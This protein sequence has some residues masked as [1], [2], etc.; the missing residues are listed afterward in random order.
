[1]SPLSTLLFLSNVVF[2]NLIYI[3]ARDDQWIRIAAFSDPGTPSTNP[4]ISCLSR[5]TYI[6]V[7]VWLLLIVAGLLLP[8]ATGTASGDVTDL[9]DL[10]RSLP[11]LPAIVM[12]G[13]VAAMLSTADAQL[14]V[15][16]QL[17]LVR[18]N[19][20]ELTASASVS[21]RGLILGLVVGTVFA[22]LTSWVTSMGI[23]DEHL[24]FVCFGLPVTIFPALVRIALRRHV[25]ISDVVAPLMLYLALSAYGLVQQPEEL[26]PYLLG[27]APMAGMLGCMIALCRAGRPIEA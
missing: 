7:A 18:L 12:T 8:F 5:A 17:A 9:L 25:A 6:T 15:L 23:R 27:A 16:R 10:G 2:V 26:S 13:M 19:D 1:L 14:Y 21:R 24:V 11:L 20:L 22:I 4:A 3:V